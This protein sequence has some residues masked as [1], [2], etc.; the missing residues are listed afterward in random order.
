MNHIEK[1]AMPE[2]GV[3]NLLVKKGNGK[4]LIRWLIQPITSGGKVIE[5]KIIGKPIK[6]KYKEVTL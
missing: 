1:S 3:G 5:Y 4:N 2:I 6:N